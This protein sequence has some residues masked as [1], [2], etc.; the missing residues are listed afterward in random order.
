MKDQCHENKKT[1]PHPRFCRNRHCSVPALLDVEVQPFGQS[2]NT[3]H[4][5]GPWSAFH[6]MISLKGHETS[7]KN[8]LQDCSADEQVGFPQSLL[9]DSRWQL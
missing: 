2:L 9:A 1:I 4:R 5:C 6:C 3:L 8:T 7:V